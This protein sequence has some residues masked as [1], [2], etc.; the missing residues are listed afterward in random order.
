MKERL[1]LSDAV[2][3]VGKRRVRVAG[4]LG[5]AELFIVEGAELRRQAAQ[6]PDEPEVRLDDSNDVSQLPLLRKLKTTLRLALHFNEW[7][8]RCEKILG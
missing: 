4:Q 7:I 6:R 1:Y 3:P 2:Q 8:S 5:F